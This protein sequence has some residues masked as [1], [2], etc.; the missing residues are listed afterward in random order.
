MAKIKPLREYMKIEK[1]PVEEV[2]KTKNKLLLKKGTRL[3]NY[4]E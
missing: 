3:F 4:G 1:M 2:L